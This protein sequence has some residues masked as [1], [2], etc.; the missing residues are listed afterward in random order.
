[1]QQGGS[2]KLKATISNLHFT[3]QAWEA[4][5]PF[6][7]Q[8]SAVCSCWPGHCPASLPQVQCTQSRNT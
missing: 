1:M 7:E 3:S 8:F 5:T 6:L 2:H 4:L